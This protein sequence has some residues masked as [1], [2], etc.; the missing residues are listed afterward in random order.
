LG[1]ESSAAAACAICCRHSWRRPF[2][3]WRLQAGSSCRKS[4]AELN[5]ITA[6]LPPGQASPA[7]SSTAPRTWIKGTKSTTRATKMMA[8]MMMEREIGPRAA[9]TRVRRHR[10]SLLESSRP[11]G[12]CV[13][14]SRPVDGRLRAK[15]FSMRRRLGGTGLS[16]RSY[17]LSSSPSLSAHS[18]AR[19]TQT[20]AYNH[21]HHLATVTGGALAGIPEVCLAST[22][23]SLDGTGGAGWRAFSCR[24]CN[25]AGLRRLRYSFRVGRKRCRT[26]TSERLHP[27]RSA[28]FVS[29]CVFI[30]RRTAALQATPIYQSTLCA[31]SR[32]VCQPKP[33]PAQ[34]IELRLPMPAACKAHATHE[35]SSRGPDRSDDGWRTPAVGERAAHTIGADSSGAPHQPAQERKRRLDCRSSALDQPDDA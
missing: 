5:H 9:F 4:R 28:V 20:H 30:G 25:G 19:C 17:L 11:A 22:L 33:P 12:S 24:H 16:K 34:E 7:R 35:K 23:T 14:S 32:P 8:A 29:S 1:F 6:S 27:Y 31:V 26:T 2:E 21:H 10:L 15:C 13:S 18:L 3:R